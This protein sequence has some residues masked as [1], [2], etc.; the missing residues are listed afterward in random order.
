MMDDAEP[1]PLPAA[2][3]DAPPPS[4]PTTAE[5]RFAVAATT[6]TALALYRPRTLKHGDTFLVLDHH[7]DAQALWETAEGLFHHDTRHLSRVVVSINGQRPL[8]LSSGV[9]D[10]NAL[11][12]VDMTN[13]DLPRGQGRPVLPRDTVHVRRVIVLG[14]GALHE[15]LYVRNYAAEEVTIEIGLTHNAD[16][17]DIF[18]VRGARR[19]RR[20]QPLPVVNE[21]MSAVAFSYLGLDGIRRDTRVEYD[22]P[23][24]AHR[25]GQATYVLRLAPGELRSLAVAVRCARSGAEATEGAPDT[26]AGDDPGFD[27][28]AARHRAWT[29]ARL[30]EVAHIH[31]SNEAFNDWLN[32][33]RAD[34]DMLCTNGPGGPFPYA[35]IPWF[36]TA[37]GRDSLITALQCLWLDP[38]LASGVLRRLAALQATES[39]PASDAEPGKILHETR[40]GEMAA[41]G[42]VP[43]RRY[44]GSV[45]ATPLFVM[46]AA[47]HLERTGDRALARSLWPNIEAALGWMDRHGDRD[48]DGFIEYFRQTPEGLSNQGWKDSWDSVFHADGRLAEGPIALVE[49]QAYAYAAW[50]GAA[51][52]ARALGREARAAELAARAEALRRRFDEAFWCE[53]LGTYALALDGEKRPCRV[54]SSNAGH[55][56]L[57][58]IAPTERAVRVAAALL[59]PRSF[60]GW[61]VRTIAEGEARYNPMSYHN[62]SVW[63]HDNGL[64]ALG[65]SR[66]DLREPLVRLLGGL[67]DAALW[68]DMK[69]LPELFCGFPRLPGQGP[70][71]YPVACLPQAWASASAFAVL[72]ALLGVAFRP[73]ERQIRFLRPVLPPWLE[74]VRIENLRI[75]TASADVVLQRHEQGEVSLNLLRR[76]GRVEVAVIS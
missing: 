59:D 70:T 60:C 9:S 5:E 38:A 21:G 73:Q 16:F 57:T 33:S 48:G 13:P 32:R 55:A 22:P 47:A 4:S 39:D 54:R 35:G 10:D 42:E 53:D 52:I 24:D 17:A 18:E 46:L 51:R 50:R 3:T 61:G 64:I 1:R 26:A 62:G 69:R 27:G 34:L 28:W 19:E 7:G 6:A 45:D 66:Y 65:L 49:V 44:Y 72:G 31:T 40:G 25:D 74:V 71:S 30:R 36:S 29:A 20:G 2:A 12:T 14:D 37:F 41:T 43:F 67:F 15:R 11:L 23:P 76:R 8:L 56:L 58:G 75:G 68:T 63:P